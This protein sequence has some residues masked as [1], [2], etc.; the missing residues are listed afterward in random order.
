MRFLNIG[1]L[2]VTIFSASV[3]FSQ[4]LKTDGNWLLEHIDSTEK[5]AK[6]TNASELDKH[7]AIVLGFYFKGFIN[8]QKYTKTISPLYIKLNEL[9]KDKE[10]VKRMEKFAEIYSPIVFDKLSPSEAFSRIKQY[11]LKN[12]KER[13]T[14]GVLVMIDALSSKN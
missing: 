8:S 3:C 13:N 9:G 1:I 11:L 12:P 2:S 10:H 7:N 6:S 14:D 4:N 5:V